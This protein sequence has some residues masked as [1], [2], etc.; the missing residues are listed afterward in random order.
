M[1]ENK[2]FNDIHASRYIA[3]WQNAGGALYYV[4]DVDNF[5]G[6][7][8]SL[9]LNE[10]EVRHIR[11]LATNGKLELEKSAEKYIQEL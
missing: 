9:G 6:W 2:L 5:C 10:D 4:E 3:S 11:H 1:F 7:L 8:L